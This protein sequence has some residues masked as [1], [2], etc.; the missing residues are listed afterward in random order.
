VLRRPRHGAFS[1]SALVIGLPLVAEELNR[2]V[3]SAKRFIHR[4]G[5][6]DGASHAGLQSR[7]RFAAEKAASTGR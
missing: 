2:T 3:G 6:Q 4:A 1:L 5:D 7:H